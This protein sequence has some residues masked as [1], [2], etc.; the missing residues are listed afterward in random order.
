MRAEFVVKRIQCKQTSSLHLAT[1]P[2]RTIICRA[3]IRVMIGYAAGREANDVGGAELELHRCARQRVSCRVAVVSNIGPNLHRDWQRTDPPA[4]G[5][6][7][8]DRYGPLLN[9][10]PHRRQPHRLLQHRPA[11]ATVT[12]RGRKCP[13]ANFPVGFRH[14]Q[15]FS[16]RG[17]SCQATLRPIDR[18]G[19]LQSRYSCSCW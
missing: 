9:Q 12:T 11:H 14:P 1:A 3:P 10:R 15:D 5:F 17:Q 4:G 8:R 13:I 18:R 6:R 16:R 7:R 19:L 2:I